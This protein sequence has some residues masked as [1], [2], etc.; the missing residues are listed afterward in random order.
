MRKTEKH[1]R[2]MSLYGPQ[3]PDAKVRRIN[4]VEERKNGNLV[5]RI[6]FNIHGLM[7]IE[8]TNEQ[9]YYDDFV[10]PFEREMAKRYGDRLVAFGEEASNIQV[11]MFTPNPVTGDKKLARIIIFD[12]EVHI[13][14]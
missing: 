7:P 4:T 12:Y 5:Q 3:V 13:K 8:D 11:S 9:I 1:Y 2:K 6:R 10:K 14:K